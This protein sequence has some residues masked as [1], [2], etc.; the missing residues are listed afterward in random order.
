LNSASRAHGA[1]Y[2]N[3]GFLSPLYHPHWNRILVEPE[4]L[5]TRHNPADGHA[6]EWSSRNANY[7]YNEY[8]YV[9]DRRLELN[10]RK[11]ERRS[12]SAGERRHV[13]PHPTEPKV[14]KT[15]QG[16]VGAHAVPR[17]REDEF[18][19]Y[20]HYTD[21]GRTY[22]LPERLNDYERR[23]QYALDIRRPFPRKVSPARLRR[24]STDARTYRSFKRSRRDF[25][26]D[27]YSSALSG[28]ENPRYRLFSPS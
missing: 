5:G 23:R 13:A 24:T 16:I 26:D 15:R 6:N 7:N 12:R 20:S 25:I 3:P 2:G 27:K 19:A 8:E 10:R 22:R 21:D 14:P 1:F 4:A 17:F 9:D 11:D 18:Y 28:E